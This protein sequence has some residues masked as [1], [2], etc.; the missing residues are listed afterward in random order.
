MSY[1]AHGT[2]YR[3]RLHKHVRC[4]IYN[5][6]AYRH[7]DGTGAQ[8]NR[9]SVV[10]GEDGG[11]MGEGACRGRGSRWRN[12]RA[13]A[14]T[15]PASSSHRRRPRATPEAAA[16]ARLAPRC[17][18]ACC[19]WWSRRAAAVR[20]RL[21]PRL[22]ARTRRPERG[23]RRLRMLRL[24]PAA[25]AARAATTMTTTRRARADRRTPRAS[26]CRRTGT[27]GRRARQSGPPGW[28]AVAGRWWSE[29]C[30]RAARGP[31]WTPPVAQW[32]S[33]LSR[34]WL[35]GPPLARRRIPWRARPLLRDYG[36]CCC[37]GCRPT[38]ATTRRPVNGKRTL[39]FVVYTIGSLWVD[40]VLS[41][42]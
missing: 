10:G 40:R 3:V 29:R 36:C 14:E 2:L 25:D 5:I 42:R 11:W 35:G 12:R 39:N 41:C 17:R 15:L 7:E 6:W 8:R 32:R 1:C 16:A 20:R 34:T 23:R 22:L 31:P 27:D 38:L 28:A 30:T 37:S 24:R 21:L 18:P 13:R 9:S 33:T 19:S 4:E 26:R